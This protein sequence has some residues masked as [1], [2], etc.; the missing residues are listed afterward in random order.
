M[1]SGWVT[2]TFY[3]GDH[4][5]RTVTAPEDAFWEDDST[6]MFSVDGEEF[7]IR[8]ENIVGEVVTWRK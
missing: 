4:E 1:L 7:H 5:E 2:L 3:D 6:V 8:K